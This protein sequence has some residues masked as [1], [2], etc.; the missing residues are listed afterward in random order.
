MERAGKDAGQAGQPASLAASNG[1]MPN[2][3]EPNGKE[4]EDMDVEND[5]LDDT[6]DL[7]V[8]QAICALREV[9]RD[10]NR[11]AA[12]VMGRMVRRFSPPRGIPAARKPP[13]P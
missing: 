3:K 5:E 11:T 12:M 9:Q 1:R 13:R 4:P 7:E 6:Q 8:H 2:G 10:V